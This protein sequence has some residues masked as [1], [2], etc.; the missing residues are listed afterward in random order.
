MTTHSSTSKIA[1]AMVAV[2]I[3]AAAML[4]VSGCSLLYPHAGATTFPTDTAEPKPTKT[5]KPKPTATETPSP[6]PTPT[7]VKKKPATVQI[8][9]ASVDT[10]NGVVTAIAQVT[11]AFEDG[12]QC[13]L[14]VKSGG[15]SK[16]QTVKAETNVSTTQCYPMEVDL[17]GLKSGDATVTV[18]Y[19]SDKFSGTSD[20]WDVVIP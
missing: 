5:A 19:S 17:A 8:D 12:G 20:T 4:T 2:A 11:N 6:T 1:K 3:G 10:D 9:D 15:T 13:T 14:T 18:S 16:T 7:T